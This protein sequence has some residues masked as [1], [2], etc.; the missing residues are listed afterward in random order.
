MHGQMSL[1]GPS[2][3]VRIS[4]PLSSKTINHHNNPFNNRLSHRGQPC[5]QSHFIRNNSAS[6]DDDSL[7][8]EVETNSNYDANSY[9]SGNAN[10]YNAISERLPASR[11]HQVTNQKWPRY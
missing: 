7:M 6:L 5:P 9:L 1:A 11:P 8:D 3:I 10:E 2:E 4:H